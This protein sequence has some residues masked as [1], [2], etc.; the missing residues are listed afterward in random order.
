MDK[1]RT[2]V[3]P[4]TPNVQYFNIIM[5]GESGAGKSS[6]LKTFTTA[7]SNKEEIADIQRIGPSTHGK[8]SVSQQVHFNSCNVSKFKKNHS[9][10]LSIQPFTLLNML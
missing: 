10:S 9:I 2:L 4:L 1:F 7:L 8:K 5:V 6:L 3:Y